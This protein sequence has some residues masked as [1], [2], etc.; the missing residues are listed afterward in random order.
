MSAFIFYYR[1]QPSWASVASVLHK[2]V[3]RCS[4]F[5]DYFFIFFAGGFLLLYLI[6]NMAEYSTGF[7]SGDK[8]W[9]FVSGVIVM[10]KN[11]TLTKCLNTESPLFSLYLSIQ[12]RIHGA[13]YKPISHLSYNVCTKAAQPHIHVL[14]LALCRHSGTPGH[15]HAKNADVHLIQTNLCWFHLTNQCA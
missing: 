5:T 8:V 14:S 1:I 12:S 13:I 11:S 4:V 15:V 10:L 6:W 7:K 9:D 2:S 3:K